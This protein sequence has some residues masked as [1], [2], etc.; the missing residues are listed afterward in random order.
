[1]DSDLDWGQDLKRLLL[2]AREMGVSE[3]WIH[4]L[5]SGYLESAGAALLPEFQPELRQLKPYEPVSGWVAIDEYSIKVEGETLR[6]E[7]AADRAFDWLEAYPFV[8]IGKSIRLYHVPP[9]T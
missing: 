2:K 7:A 4:C 8:R 1:M 9:G 3:L 5:G 6:R